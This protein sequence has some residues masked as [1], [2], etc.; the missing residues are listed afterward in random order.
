MASAA[1]AD[2]T[3]VL[4]DLF[5]SSDNLDLFPTQVSDHFYRIFST[6]HALNEVGF[7]D[8]TYPLLSFHFLIDSVSPCSQSPRSPQGQILGSIQCHG[9]GH[10]FV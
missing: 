10:F 2:P 1:L 7:L 9:S 6:D 4:L 5:H 8:F 3:A